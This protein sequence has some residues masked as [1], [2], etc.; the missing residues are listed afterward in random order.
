MAGLVIIICLLIFIITIGIYCSPCFIFYAICSATI[1]IG[2]GYGGRGW[3][4]GEGA[5]GGGGGVDLAE[6]QWSG[7]RGRW[8]WKGVVM[9]GRGGGG[10][11]VATRH[12]SSSPC[13]R[14]PKL[15]NPTSADH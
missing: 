8:R 4:A 11:A 14:P 13:S 3:V 9:E 1:L 7:Y 5:G 12:Q 15:N 6:G 2:G 10:G